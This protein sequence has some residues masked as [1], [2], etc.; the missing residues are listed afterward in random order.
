[1][2]TSTAGRMSDARQSAVFVL[3]IFNTSRCG[4]TCVSVTF[5][6][7][8]YFLYLFFFLIKIAL[9]HEVLI[10]KVLCF[11]SHTKKIISTSSGVKFMKSEQHL[12]NGYVAC[13]LR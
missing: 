5:H 11:H 7:F 2:A 3:E 8:I 6:I 1:M 13:F 10:L 9:R 4:R 12:H